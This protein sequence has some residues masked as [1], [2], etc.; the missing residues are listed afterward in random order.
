MK[1]GLRCFQSRRITFL[2]ATT[3]A[4]INNSRNFSLHGDAPPP[5]SCD[6]DIFSLEEEEEG[7]IKQPVVWLGK[8]I[9]AFTVWWRHQ[10][11]SS[12]LIFT[13]LED[14]WSALCCLQLSDLIITSSFS[15]RVIGPGGTERD[16]LIGTQEVSF[17]YW[18]DSLKN[19]RTSLLES[20]L[21]PST[22]LC[23]SWVDLEK[24]L[25]VKSSG[26]AGG[27]LTF[28][29]DQTNRLYT[30][31]IFYSLYCLDVCIIP[32]LMCVI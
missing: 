14:T 1:P 20:R 9:K 18:D 6:V 31:K 21:A 10:A 32:S 2:T 23:P 26:T 7:C 29:I 27:S 5:T 25:I 8:Q 12:T 4:I 16:S 3:R 15:R 22:V 24:E 30:D 17:P 13:A 11:I 19:H 28:N